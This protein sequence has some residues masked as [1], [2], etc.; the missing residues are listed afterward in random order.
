MAASATPMPLPLH[1]AKI[2]GGHMFP[3]PPLSVPMQCTAGLTLSS[4]HH[5]K[6]CH[7]E[8]LHNVQEYNDSGVDKAVWYLL[9]LIL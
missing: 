2:L 9:L 3:V 1:T 4:P 5:T 8:K 7:F 6:L